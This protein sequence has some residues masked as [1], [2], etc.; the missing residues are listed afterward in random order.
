MWR[1]M[2]KQTPRM[3]Q[4]ERNYRNIHKLQIYGHAVF[5]EAFSVFAFSILTRVTHTHT[6]FLFTLSPASFPLRTNNTYGKSFPCTVCMPCMV[7]TTH[8]C[9]SI[10]S[11]CLARTIP[12]IVHTIYQHRWQTNFSYEIP[13]LCAKKKKR[14]DTNKAHEYRLTV[15]C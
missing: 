15:C 3:S 10:F 2:K 4:M 9:T 1:R 6:L 11:I 14:K 8:L 12:P 7:L 5:S 13:A